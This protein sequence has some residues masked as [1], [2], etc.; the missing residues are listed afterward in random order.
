MR[1]GATKKLKGGTNSTE[2]RCTNKKIFLHQIEGDCCLKCHAIFYFGVILQDN[3]V[4]Y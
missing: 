3:M 2:M 4:K 1:W